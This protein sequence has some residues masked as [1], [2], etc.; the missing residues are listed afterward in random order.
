VF[1]R[2]IINDPLHGFI[3]IDD[4]LIFKIIQHPYYQR[5]SRIKQMALAY[6][7]YPG[8]THTRFQHSLGAYYLMCNALTE[9]KEKGFEITPPEEQATKIAILLHDI[10]HGPFSHALEETI[11]DCRH[12]EISGLIMQKLNQEMNG[13]LDLAIQIFKG[14]TEKKFLHQLVSSQLDV[15]RLDYLARDSFYSGVSEGV[16]GYDRIVKMLTVHQ[17]ELAVEEK[18]IHSIEKF[19]IARRLMYLQVYL[20][21]TVLSAENILIQTLR[22]AKELSEQNEILFASPALEFFMQKKYCFADFEKTPLCLDNFLKLDDYDILGAIKV[23][24]TH[25][26]SILKD[27]SNRLINRNLY[28][29][30]FSTTPLVDKLEELKIQVQTKFKCAKESLKYF[31]ISDNTSNIMY[32]ET[33]TSIKILF[34]NGE[35]KT[36]QQMPDTLITAEIIEPVKKYYICHA[37]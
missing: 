37:T 24:S 7:V 20:H 11:V 1:F 3:T 17:N 8:A 6:L 10:G 21:K 12:E 33:D 28:K 30:I 25:S 5:L 32:S 26:D 16:I 9:L 27:L 14:A 22:R 4:P 35:I 19:L 2:K 29:T 36:L 23:W 13:A 34:K 31:V 15:D 18:G